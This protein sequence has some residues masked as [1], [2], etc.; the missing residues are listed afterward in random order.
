MTTSRTEKRY[1]DHLKTGV[2]NHIFWSEIGSGFGEPGGTPSPGI[3]RST[4]LGVFRVQHLTHHLKFQRFN[5]NPKK[6]ALPKRR[7]RLF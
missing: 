6:A 3:P 7:L 2:E 5:G 4:P 1:G